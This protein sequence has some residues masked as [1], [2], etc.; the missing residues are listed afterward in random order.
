MKNKIFKYVLFTFGL[1]V[2]FVMYLWTLQL[3]NI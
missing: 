1:W 2:L 3:L